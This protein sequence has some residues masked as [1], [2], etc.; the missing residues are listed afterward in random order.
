MSICEEIA[1]AY[2]SPPNRISNEAKRALFE[3]HKTQSFTADDLALVVRFI[4]KHKA[5]KFGKDAP[6]IAQSASRAVEV[7][8]E[9]LQRAEAA[10]E[11][12]T[13]YQAPKPMQAPERDEELSAEQKAEISAGFAELKNKMRIGGEQDG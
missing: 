4:A 3:A 9:L 6:K 7:F 12:I 8:P 11:T 1:K 13:P 5:G 2:G 10:R